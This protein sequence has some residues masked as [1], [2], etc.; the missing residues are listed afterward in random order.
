LVPEVL[1][2]LQAEMSFTLNMM[3]RFHRWRKRKMSERAFITAI[4]IVAGL[5]SGLAAVILKNTI[6]FT[7]SPVDSLVSQEMHNY[8]Y[9]ALPLIGITLTVLLILFKIVATS[10]T[11]GA[12]GTG[13]IFAPT[14]FMGVN[15]G[16]LFAC[17][18]NLFSVQ[19]IKIKAI[20]YM[21]ECYIDPDDSMEVA[22]NKFETSGRYN[23]AVI[24][25]NEK[26]VGFL[27]RAKVFTR[28]RKQITDVSHV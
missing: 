5:F 13:R 14:L 11:F 9:F 18:V 19:K 1:L 20:M 22:A 24:D 21:P 3:A 6:N 16:I 27:S 10:L 7:H 26:Y 8:V 12:G 23:L 4:S 15:T 25:K 28:Y 17:I 2:L